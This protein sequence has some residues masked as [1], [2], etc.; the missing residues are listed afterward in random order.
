MQSQHKD[1]HWQSVD[2]I[3]YKLGKTV[4][5]TSDES[6]FIYE[7]YQRLLPEIK[8]IAR[9]YLRLDHTL[10]LGDFLG[11][12]YLAVRDALLQ[13]KRDRGHKFSTYAYW[14]F[15]K[16]FENLCCK[17][18]VVVL[19]NGYNSSVMSYKEFQKIKKSLPEGTEWTVESRLI[20]FEPFQNTNG[21]PNRMS[22]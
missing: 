7:L 22:M 5:R 12:G 3:F 17:D 15:Q 19:K 16:R 20:P 14:H 4:E 8:Y 10:E 21:N 13:Y 2:E 18:K 1:K 11:E 9:R 6:F